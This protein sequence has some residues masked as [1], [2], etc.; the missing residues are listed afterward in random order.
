MKIKNKKI[1]FMKNKINIKIKIHVRNITRN[2][3]FGS[4][5]VG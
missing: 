5:N 3:Y 2:K 1:N 4:I